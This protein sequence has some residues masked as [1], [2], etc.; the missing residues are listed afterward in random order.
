MEFIASYSG[1]LGRNVPNPQPISCGTAASTWQDAAGA[2][3]EDA[4]RSFGGK[5]WGSN[6]C[7][8]GAQTEASVPPESAIPRR[9]SAETDALCCC[10]A[11]MERNYGTVAGR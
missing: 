11:H 3:T 6:G 2:P 4:R 9:I 7:C 8:V 10:E 1:A 5:R